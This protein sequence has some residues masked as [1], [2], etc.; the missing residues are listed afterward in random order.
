[1]CYIDLMDVTIRNVDESAYRALK[2]R[3]ALN[4]KTVGE[5]VNE[6]MKAFLGRPDPSIKVPGSLAL[7]RPI[8]FPPG[9]EHLSEEID[10]IVYGI[11]DPSG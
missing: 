6:A 5:L 8:Q 4:G 1:L 7:L 9:N 2:A 10:Q 3:A 11:A